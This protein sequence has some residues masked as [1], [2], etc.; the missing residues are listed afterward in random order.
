MIEDHI[1]MYAMGA[2]FAEGAT[3]VHAVDLD[4]DG[5]MD[6]LSA[7]AWDDKIAWNENMGGGLFGPQ[8]TITISAGHPVIFLVRVH[9]PVP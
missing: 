6:V 1:S 2:N 9:L 7:S 8:D 4:G 5:D 3:S